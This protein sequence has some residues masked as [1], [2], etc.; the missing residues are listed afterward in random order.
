M[1]NFFY[2]RNSKI[3]KNIFLTKLKIKVNKIK[4][5]LKF[6]EKLIFSNFNSNVLLI[7]KSHVSAA[8]PHTQP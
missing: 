2:E 4:Y 3:H 7:F 8:E 5:I 1:V 6:L